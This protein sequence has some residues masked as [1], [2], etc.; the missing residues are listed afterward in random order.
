MRNLAEQPD[1][2]F[3]VVVATAWRTAAAVSSWWNRPRTIYYVQHYEVWNGSDAQVDATWRLPYELVVSSEWLRALAIHKFCRS[4]AVV[5]PYGVDSEL[6]H[7]SR[8]DSTTNSN[9]RVGFLY[10]VEDWK[11][12]SDTLEAVQIVRREHDIDLVAFGAFDNRGDLPPE[13]E[14]HLRPERSD[15]PAIYSSLDAF[16]CGSWSETGPMTVPEAM[17]CGTPIVSTD[18]GNVRLWT[19]GGRAA[20]IAPPRQPRRLARALADALTNPDE[21]HRRAAAGLETIAAFTWDRAA[22]AFAA[23]VERT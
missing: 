12:V 3:D 23:V 13:T 14:F 20:W 17:A 4:D 2:P 22:D 8:R 10:H 6:F 9:P 7:P 18:V 1:E 21:R 19:D 5:V 16:V 15:L 11:G